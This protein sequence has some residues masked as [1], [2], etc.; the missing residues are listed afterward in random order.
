VISVLVFTRDDA[1][2]LGRC[3]G[4]LA[5]DSPEELDVVVFDNVST[6]D[7][8]QVVRSWRGA[9]GEQARLITATVDTS[10]SE[11]NNAL[12]AAADGDVSVILNPDTEPSPAMLHALAERLRTSP[13]IAMVGPRLV[14]PDGTP[15]SNGWRLPTPTQLLAERLAR[16][17]REVPPSGAGETDVG[18]LMG[19]CLAAHTPELRAV[20]GFD[21]GFWFHGT[22]LELCGRMGK[23]GRIV[24]LDEHVLIHRGH[25]DWTPERITAARKATARWLLRSAPRLLG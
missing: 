3:L 4:A 16:R 11:G 9:R 22:D 7:T 19:C 21:L 10:F 12:I 20:G 13:R 1:A 14:F 6:D 23:R 8:G 15:Q 24:R 5:G 18:W 25:R 2:W 17:E